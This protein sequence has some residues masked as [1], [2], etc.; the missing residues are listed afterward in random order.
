MRKK[1]IK[2][3]TIVG[4]F[5][6]TVWAALNVRAANGLYRRPSKKN[7]CYNNIFIRFTRAEFKQWCWDHASDVEALQQPSLD[8]LNSDTDYTLD[9][10]RVIELEQNKRRSVF[11]DTT[12]RCFRCKATKPIDEFVSTRCT[13]NGKTSICKPCEAKR[14]PRKR[15]AKKPK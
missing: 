13:S 6:H 7:D 10:I 14:K 12:G 9:N 11:T 4:S 3:R 15:F 8:R 1:P 2:H 5:V